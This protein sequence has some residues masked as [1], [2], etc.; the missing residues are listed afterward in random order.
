MI[1]LFTLILKLM[2]PIMKLQNEHLPC[3]VPVNRLTSRK[4]INVVFTK[5]IILKIS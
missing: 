2:K 3:Y 4:T 5:S 1:K